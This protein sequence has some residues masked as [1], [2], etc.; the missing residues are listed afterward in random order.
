MTPQILIEHLLFTMHENNSG[1]PEFQ[2][3]LSLLCLLW[4]FDIEN[5]LY[6]FDIENYI[7]FLF[8]IHY[9]LS[10]LKYT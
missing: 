8:L 9:F 1:G 6:S 3:W 7:S 5:Y 10:T 4:D 2:H